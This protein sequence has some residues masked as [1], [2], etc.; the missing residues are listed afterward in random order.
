VRLSAHSQPLTGVY[1]W[2]YGVT[3]DAA[4][5]KCI[6]IC[7]LSLLQRQCIYIPHIFLPIIATKTWQRNAAK[8]SLNSVL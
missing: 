8:L 7:C 1:T 4:M 6:K 5:H 3:H 2:A